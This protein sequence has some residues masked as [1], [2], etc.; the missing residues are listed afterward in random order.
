MA[1]KIRLK[2]DAYTVGLIYVKPLEMHAITAMLDEHHE[3][4]PMRLGDDNEYTL[5]KIGYHNVAI[6]GPPRGAQ[7]KVA[8]ANVVGRI[9]LAFK[10]IRVGL[11][12][13]IGGGVPH[14]PES[15]VRLGDVVVG[16]PEVGPAVVQYDFGKQ[17]PDG[18]EVTRTLNKPPELLLKVV[19][20]VEDRYQ[21]ASEGT[22]DFFVKHLRRFAEFPRMG[23]R[24]KRPSIPDRLFRAE[25]DHPEG[26]FCSTHDHLQEVKR[27]DRDRP[28]E[29]RIHYSTILSGDLVMKSGLMRDQISAKHH[30][31][32]CFEMEAAG[33][34]DVFPCLVIRGICDYS[35]SHKSKEWQEYAAAVA[36]AYAREILL[37]MAKRVLHE[38]EDP[39]IVGV[40]GAPQAA[41]QDSS[42][43]GED[44]AR[45]SNYRP[46][47]SSSAKK[48]ILSLDGGGIRGYSSL[49]ILER[50]MGEIKKTLGLA[51]APL[52]CQYFDIIGGAGTGGYIAAESF[53]N[54]YQRS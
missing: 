13:G 18:V 6:V 27:P 48:S 17:L 30:N 29:V 53:L 33:L 40:R 43:R 42:R 8:I 50:L 37:T 1:I 34:M 23:D 46:R 14:L 36:A 52:P 26:T 5:G 39:E 7:G 45:D 9:C 47:A 22:E 10:N 15:D 54:L 19:D 41:G 31:A 2:A 20:K 3:A 44:I 25:Y 35:D 24:Y 11:L 4:V 32:V 21:R 38:L 16:A 49:M 28:H 51:T 12:V